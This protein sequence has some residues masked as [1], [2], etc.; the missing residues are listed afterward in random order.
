MRP[1]LELFAALSRN[2]NRVDRGQIS[3]QRRETV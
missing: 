1:L 3:R 2:L